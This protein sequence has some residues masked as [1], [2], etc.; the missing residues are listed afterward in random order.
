MESLGYSPYV[1]TIKVDKNCND[2]ESSAFTGCYRLRT[3]SMPA[4]GIPL[5]EYVGSSVQSLEILYNGSMDHIPSS[6]FTSL[7]SLRTVEV[8]D[9]FTQ[10]GS[11]IFDSSNIN[12][13]FN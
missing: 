10:A 8:E 13:S 11:L 4:V 5:K 7:S 1:E 3:L 6:Y 12:I 2:I 9:G